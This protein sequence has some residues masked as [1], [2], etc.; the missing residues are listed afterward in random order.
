MSGDSITVMTHP[1]P[2]N[3]LA[4]MLAAIHPAVPPPTIAMRLIWLGSLI[5]LNFAA[6]MLLHRRPA[7][8]DTAA[9]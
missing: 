3:D 5:G 7:D 1:V 6:G 4:R 2:G 8:D 9:P